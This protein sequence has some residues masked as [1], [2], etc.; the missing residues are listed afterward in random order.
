MATL[1]RVEKLLADVKNVMRDS[2]P[3][4]RAR[5]IQKLEAES[6][7]GFVVRDQDRLGDMIPR[8]QGKGRRRKSS[9]KTKRRSR[10]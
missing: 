7:S 6:P 1:D 3:E 4:E 5:V 9:R 2:T 10:K 8:P